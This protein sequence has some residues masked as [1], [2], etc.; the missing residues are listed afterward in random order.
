MVV[1]SE[2]LLVVLVPLEEEEEDE[3]RLSSAERADIIEGVVVWTSSAQVTFD[4]RMWGVEEVF[5]CILLQLFDGA[6]DGLMLLLMSI[7]KFMNFIDNS[8]LK[9]KK[10]L[11]NY[12]LH[13]IHK[14]T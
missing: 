3:G 13:F 2:L 8:I 12:S 4:V 5:I 10:Y 7:Y 6:V 14:S 9:F 1:A 11:F